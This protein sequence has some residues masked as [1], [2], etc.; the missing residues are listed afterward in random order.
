MNTT[1]K[2]PSCASRVKAAF[3]SRMQDIRTLY[4]AED[5]H[6]DEIGDLCD[7]GLCIDFVSAGTFRDQREPY[8]RYQLSWGG[9]SEEF[10]VFL[11]GDVEFWFLDWFD[12]TCVPVDGEDSDIIR[13]IVR[14]KYENIDRYPIDYE[15]EENETLAS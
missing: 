11:N 12:G 6:E 7:Y 3:E 13:D 9:P 1:Q 8:Y 4:N 15:G 5:Q 2:D 14:M 10:R